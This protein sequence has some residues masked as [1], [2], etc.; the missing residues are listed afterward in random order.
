M[1]M[2]TRRGSE[3]S[4]RGSPPERVY[5]LLDVT[6]QRERLRAAGASVPPADAEL[7]DEEAAVG[8]GGADS[9]VKLMSGNFLGEFLKLQGV[10][11][12]IAES[13]DMPV[14][15]CRPKHV[16]PV[17]ERAFRQPEHM[18]PCVKPGLY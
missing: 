5:T 17:S 7:R 12:V 15:F 14:G 13:L 10:A 11:V 6:S 2:G 1:K 3:R 4:S 16:T 18:P 9:A 8:R